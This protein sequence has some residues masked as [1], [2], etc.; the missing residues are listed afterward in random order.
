[1]PLMVSDLRWLQPIVHDAVH[2]VPLVEERLHSLS[3]QAIAAI[4]AIREVLSSSVPPV[5]G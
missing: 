5:L 3:R 2:L 4:L 1:M